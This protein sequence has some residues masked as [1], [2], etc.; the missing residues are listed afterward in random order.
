MIQ[1]N[2]E[3]SILLLDILA[4]LQKHTDEEHGVE[5]KDIINILERE[6]GYENLK[7]R[8]L[9]VKRNLERLINYHEL[10]SLNDIEIEKTNYRRDKDLITGEVNEVAVHS[11]FVYKHTFTHEE[12]HLIIDSIL[13]SK[14]IPDFYKKELIEKLEKLTSKHF[15]SRLSRV[16]TLSK[17]KPINK[18]LFYTIKELDQAIS[19]KKKV[20]FYYNQYVI[21]EKSELAL[22]QRTDDKGNARQY[23]IN[24]YELVAANGH[25]YV[26]C[27]ND[28]YDNL[29]HYRVD[30]ISN[31]HI[32]DE[33]RR[34]VN[35]FKG[36]T[37][38]LDLAKYMREH[39][40][41]FAGDIVGVR[42]RFNKRVLGEFVDWFGTEEILFSD[43]TEDEVTVSVRV[44]RTAMR[45][46]ALQY[47]IYVRVLSPNDLVADIKRDIQQV[48]ENYE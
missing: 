40:Y 32:S 16:H 3:D 21:D 28:K 15:N 44:N 10:R 24:P 34:P 5:Q 47:G 12:L 11:G 46:W 33:K 9:T 6:Y 13:F 18:Q 45:K 31:I 17:N 8:R 2:P 42:M 7:R 38:G 14:Q 39:I 23:V 19:E 37:Y 4:V 41:M 29:S 30:R 35:D 36:F 27:N 26:I 20:S 25:Y 1:M 22:Q 43:Q 48:L